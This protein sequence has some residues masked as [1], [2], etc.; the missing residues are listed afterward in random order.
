MTNRADAFGHDPIERSEDDRLERKDFADLL[1]KALA[2]S[3]ERRSMVVA[4]YGDWGSGKTSTLNL[5]FEAL[6]KLPSD[7]QPLVVR[8]NPWWY[9]NT[10]ELL[11]QFF[12]EIGTS[13][14]E[15]A[16]QRGITALSNIKGWLVSYRKLIAPAGGVAD[17]FV[18]GGLLT[19]LATLSQA[20]AERTAQQQGDRDI[21]EIRSEIEKALLVA[22]QR[23][24]IAIDDIDRLSASEIRDIFKLVKATADFPNTRYLLAFDFDTVVRAL[25]DVQHTNGA[26]Y[27]EKIVQVPFRLPDPAPGQLMTIVAEGMEEI[28]SLHED[29]SEEDIKHVKEKLD[30]LAVYGLGALWNN[31]RRVNRVLDSLRLTLPAF[32]GEIRLSDLVL[33]EALRVTEPRVYE[34]ILDGQN[35]LVGA[36]P[37]AKILLTRSGSNDPQE[38]INQAT[39]ALVEAV[40]EATERKE[41]RDVIT[42]VLEELF[43]RVEAIRRGFGAYGPDFLD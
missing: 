23:V 12:E 21:H 20:A 11:A 16:K 14:E 33:L 2:G 10:G 29:I 32:A 3:P 35:L 4:L 28:A 8:F 15:Q 18:S 31:M 6:G 1:A 36:T 38:Q 13:L 27:L 37:G 22:K 40:S 39:A 24:V 41:L 26:A 42:R 25:S 9:S 7:E 30:L 5:C 17:L 43:P 19:A 34:L